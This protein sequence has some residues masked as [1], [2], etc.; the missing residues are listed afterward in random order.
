METLVHKTKHI[1]HNK[2]NFIDLTTPL[3]L[4]QTNYPNNF[5]ILFKRAIITLP[6]P[7]IINPRNRVIDRILYYVLLQLIVQGRIVVNLLINNERL[8]RPV[9]TQNN[10]LI[11]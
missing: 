7:R 10:T 3:Y 2:R 1:T 8:N 4:N 11:V 5:Q 6:L 9:Q